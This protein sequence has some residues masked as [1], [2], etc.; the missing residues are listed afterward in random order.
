MA[1]TALP[2]TDE[3]GTESAEEPLLAASEAT[4]IAMKKNPISGPHITH[5]FSPVCRCSHY[6][7][8]TIKFRLQQSGRLTLEVERK[9]QTAIVQNRVHG[10]YSWLMMKSQSVSR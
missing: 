2:P 6:P 7:V 5:T 8:A 1:G 4:L 3:D 10:I 9:E